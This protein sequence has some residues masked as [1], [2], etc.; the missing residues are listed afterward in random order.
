MTCRFYDTVICNKEKLISLVP[1]FI[2]KKKNQSFILN[3]HLLCSYLVGTKHINYK[4]KMFL[5]IIS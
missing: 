1:V 4:F 2:Y 5:L 3:I